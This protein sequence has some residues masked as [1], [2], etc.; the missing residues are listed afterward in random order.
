VTQGTL[1]TER[2]RTTPARLRTW[3]V[4]LGLLLAASALVCAFAATDLVRS[5]TEIA[6]NTGPV[7]IETQGLVASIAEADAANTAVFLSG[8]NEDRQQRRLYETALERAP[9]QIEEISARLGDSPASHEALQSVGSQLTQYAGVVEQART[10]NTAGIDGATA[11]LQQALDLASGTSGMLDNVGTVSE[12]SEIRLNEDIA[13]SRVL[14]GA[15]AALLAVSIVS[16]VVAQ[17]SLRS[18]TKRLINPGLLLATVITSAALIW[19][20]AAIVTRTADLSDARD[21]GYDAIALTGEL[22]TEAFAYKTREAESIIG[23]EAFSDADRAA[24]AANIE[25][26]IDSVIA[27]SD[28]DREAATAAELATRWDRYLITSDSIAAALAASEDTARAIAI[29]DGNRDFNGFN[30]TVEAVLLNNRDQF[31][32]SVAS[33]AN[34]LAWI[35]LGMIALPLLAAVCVLAGYQPRINEYW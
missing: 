9:R 23:T 1:S 2:L 20:T 34:R 5:T 18:L 33:A 29:T 8:V 26:I 13:V 27:A 22:Q 24:S 6:D 16:L 12:Q 35:V 25:A 31:D 15:T 3:S 7:L 14:L 28:T 4:V 11:N 17:F 10:K 30:T 19:F 32:S 21:D